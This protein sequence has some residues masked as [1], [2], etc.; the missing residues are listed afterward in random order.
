MRLVEEA[1]PPGREPVI[2]TRHPVVVVHALLHDAPAAR[3]YEE[4]RVVIE[5]VAVLH[6][7]A[8]HLRRHPAGIDERPR[9]D[10]QPLAIRENL[11]GR[12]ARRRALAAADVDPE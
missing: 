1:L 11:S 2:A 12:L 8:V 10:R 6:R 5:L 7:G 9:V 4:E 3:R